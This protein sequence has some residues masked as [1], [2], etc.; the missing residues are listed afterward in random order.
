MDEQ[1]Y[2]EMF[3][4]PMTSWPTDLKEL[5][6]FLVYWCS[7]IFIACDWRPGRGYLSMWISKYNSKK[8]KS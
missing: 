3:F 4:S 8:E 5:V 1:A 6:L 7:F 2:F